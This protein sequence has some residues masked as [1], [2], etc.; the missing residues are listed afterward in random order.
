MEKR[1]FRGG[2]VRLSVLREMESH[3]QLHVAVLYPAQLAQAQVD[4]P[5]KHSGQDKAQQYQAHPVPWG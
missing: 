2:K 5:G 4:D 3:V 1:A